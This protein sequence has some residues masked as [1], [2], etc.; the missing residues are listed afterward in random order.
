MSPEQA[1]GH[2]VDARSDVFSLG[3]VLYEMLTRRRPFEGKNAVEQV[4]AVLTKQPQPI[5][6]ESPLAA[7]LG[8]LSLRMI[9]KEP[10]R[11]PAD[12]REV[13]RDLEALAGGEAPASAP[14]RDHTVAVIGFANITGAR[15][16]PGSG[17]AQAEA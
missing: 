5:S 16:T 2:A 13:L 1:R 6:A 3:V 14:G 11:R 7:G 12:M 10:A 17:P 4:E 9:E 8:E 15:K